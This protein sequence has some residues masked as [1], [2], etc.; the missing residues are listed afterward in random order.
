MLA[1]RKLFRGKSDFETLK[2]VAEMD[3][4]PPSSIRPDVPPELDRI[5]AR[6]LARD[7][8]ERYPSAQ[9]L[10][11][12]LD[13][14]LEVLRQQP[15]ALPDLL[16]ELFGAELSSRQIPTTTLTTEML[17]AC[18]ADS[19]SASG[20]GASAAEPTPP[21]ASRTPVPALD[22][23]SISI[24]M[25]APVR[26]PSRWLSWVAAS[27][28]TATL[29]LLLVARG[30]GARSQGATLPAPP[31]VSIGVPSAEAASTPA[32]KIDPPPSAVSPAAEPPGKPEA[33]SSESAA[34]GAGHHARWSGKGRIARGL[35]VDPF[36]EAASRVGR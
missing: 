6:A 17:A 13:G 15:R 22:E 31:V 14:V 34:S 1:G 33:Q 29:L 18:R 23:Y 12:E 19:S 35:S 30:G 21:A 24:G 3:V 9:A 5:V 16:H 36:A 2:N 8:A 11:D 27:V 4:P 10:A 32:G 26:P 20:V 25:G 28:G 7:P